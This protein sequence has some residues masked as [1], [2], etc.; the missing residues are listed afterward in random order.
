[1]STEKENKLLN[2]LAEENKNACSFYKDA[3]N[4]VQHPILQHTFTNLEMLHSNVLKKVK[5]RIRGNGEAPDIDETI[6]GQ[7]AKSWNGIKT[8]L[9]KNPDVMLVHDLEEAE[10]RCLDKVQSIM[11]NDNVS[12]L[13]KTLL[14]SEYKKLRRSH[15]Y[16]K[17]LKDQ[18]QR[19]A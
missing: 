8:K 1:M 16:M 3:S 4:E 11:K 18:M 5:G 7:I 2:E 13:T 9:S 15:D 6:K 14:E 17:D 10:D 19:A 12:D